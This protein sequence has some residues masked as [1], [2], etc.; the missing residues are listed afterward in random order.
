M[1]VLQ[2]RGSSRGAPRRGPHVLGGMQVP[3]RV[4]FPDPLDVDR[5]RPY[6]LV[7]DATLYSFGI[8]FGG[9]GLA[10]LVLRSITLFSGR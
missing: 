2:G 1:G 3:G 4:F 8:L 9:L 6:C 5:E 10:A 7:M